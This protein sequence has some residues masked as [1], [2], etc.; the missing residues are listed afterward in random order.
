MRFRI[1][2]SLQLRPLVETDAEELYRL[3]DANRAY[4]A[5]WMPWAGEQTLAGTLEFIRSAIEQERGDDGFQLALVHQGAIAG[6]VGFHRIDRRDAT[7]TIGYWLAAEHQGKGLMTSSVE[8]LVSHAF[9]AWDLNRVEIRAAPENRRSRAICE[10]L[11]FRE[12]GLLR[13]AERF[14][15]E[16]RD[17]VL[18]AMLAAEWPAILEA[19]RAG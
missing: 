9:D 18:Y 7:T 3:V 11:G 1:S 6:T 2:E 16:Y 5:R 17:L 15:D 13:Q 4:L 19:R 12:V 10:R 14:G 8:A